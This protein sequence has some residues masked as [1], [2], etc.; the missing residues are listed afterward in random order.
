MTA[1]RRHELTDKEWERLR[2]YFPDRQEG[3]L[4]RPRNDDR[5]ILNGLLWIVRTGAPWRDLPE[6]YGSWNTVYSRFA[7]WQE[8]G[9]FET[10][11]AELGEEADLQDMGIDSFAVPVHQHGTGAKKG[12]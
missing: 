7:Q 3:E 1:Q 12:L 10:I 5:Q 8:N 11:M 9:L 4:G 2:K 6:R